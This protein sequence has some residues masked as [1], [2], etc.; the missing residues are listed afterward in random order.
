ME[1][2]ETKGKETQLAGKSS[3]KV[4]KIL[5]GGEMTKATKG[6][7]AQ[8]NKPQTEEKFLTA[9]DLAKMA[10]VE[11]RVLRRCLR[12]HFS[13][14]ITAIKGDNG[15]KTY[16][17]KAKDPIVEEILA[18]LKGNG[19]KGKATKPAKAQVDSGE[20]EEPSPESITEVTDE[21]L[22]ITESRLTVPEPIKR[23]LAK[24]GKEVKL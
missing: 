15:M 22:I 9:K 21:G 11:P 19:D 1:R 10:K 18:K 17:I 23:A 5:K 7:A 3:Q 4:D 24:Q 2:K 16:R 6:K 20:G 12:T 13:G 8:A 14:R